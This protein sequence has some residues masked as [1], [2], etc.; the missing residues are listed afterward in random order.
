[1]QNLF[2]SLPPKIAFWVG[3]I[4]GILVLSTIGFIILLSIFLKGGS[5][6][7]SAVTPSNA[8][9]SAP[10]PSPSPSAAQAPS[11]EPQAGTVKAVSDADHI[12]GNKNA[13]VFLIEYSDFECPFCKRFHPTAQQIVDAYQGRVAWV[14]RHFPL[15]FHANAQKEA[16]A[17]ECAADQ[18]GN[19]AFWKFANKIN[20]RTTSNGT[21]FAL[22]ALAPLA[23]EI[24][25]NE[26]KFKDCL[27]SGKFASKVQK[28]IAEGTV[29]GVNGTPGNLIWTKDGKTKLIPGAVPFESLK[30]TIDP[31]L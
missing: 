19:T 5:F 9:A 21:G 14:Y 31:L 22:D 25:L 16:E 28:D 1:M 12:N 6:G 17:S 24:G 3:L 13:K 10:S 29:A 20:E 15:S 4:G 30:Q 8:V 27:N 26:T 23:K 18:G 7:V 2:E 11:P